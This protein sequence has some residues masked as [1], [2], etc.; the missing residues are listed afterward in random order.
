MCFFPS[1]TH[2]AGVRHIPTFNT[3][4]GRAFVAFP[5]AAFQ[6][7]SPLEPS[8]EDLSAAF[9]SGVKGKPGLF[10]TRGQALRKKGYEP[11]MVFLDAAAKND[12]RA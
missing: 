4:V 3:K 2:N 9:V 1:L 10:N 5:S 12:P 8:H 11:L 6:H 7:A